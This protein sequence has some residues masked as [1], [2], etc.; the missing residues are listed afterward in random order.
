MASAGGPLAEELPN[1]ASHLQ[2]RFLLCRMGVQDLDGNR[3]VTVKGPPVHTS[4]RAS[5]N[6]LVYLRLCEGRVHA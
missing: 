4:R 6:A 1:P 5:P 2:R 3:R